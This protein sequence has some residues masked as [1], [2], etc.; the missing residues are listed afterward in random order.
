MIPWLHPGD[1]PDAFPPVETAFT[2]P[3]G[4]ELPGEPAIFYWPYH[5]G[6]VVNVEGTLTM[7]PK[8]PWECADMS[9]VRDEI[10]R[11]ISQR[12]P[13]RSWRSVLIR[14]REDFGIRVRSPQTLI[15]HKKYH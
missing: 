7:D 1:A 14:L 11:M 8:R 12:D 4:S 10:D 3:D 13:K 15:G 5:K 6:T 2:D 9:Q